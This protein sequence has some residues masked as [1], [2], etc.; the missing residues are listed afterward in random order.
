ML[1][2]EFLKEHHIVQDL[3]TVVAQQQRQ[4]EALTADL[5]KVSAQIELRRPE[6]QMANNH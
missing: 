3:K 4:I 1:L 6:P 2:N 5:E